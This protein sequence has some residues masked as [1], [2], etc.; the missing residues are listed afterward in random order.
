MYYVLWR[1]PSEETNALSLRERREPSQYHQYRA[2]WRYIRFY[3]IY[4]KS[5]NKCIHVIYLDPQVA[6]L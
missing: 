2:K 3:D 6:T 4:V 5:A 1:K